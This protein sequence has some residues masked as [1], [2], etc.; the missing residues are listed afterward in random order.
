MRESGTSTG[1]L[2]CLSRGVSY[3]SV[4]ITELDGSRQNS[5]NV[6]GLS[7]VD[8]SIYPSD[9]NVGQQ[10]CM[11]EFVLFSEE[12]NDDDALFCRCKNE[13]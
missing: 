2:H 12:D 11:V 8:F 5:H 1:S 10:C 3:I 4:I 6:K 13:T 7:P 9:G